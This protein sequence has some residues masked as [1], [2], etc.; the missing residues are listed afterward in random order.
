MKKF[1]FIMIFTVLLLPAVQSVATMGVFVDQ[2]IVH[3]IRINKD[4]S[5]QTQKGETYAVKSEELKTKLSN[6]VGHSARI[7]Y[8][9]SLC[10]DISLPS[11]PP[12]NIKKPSVQSK[13][14]L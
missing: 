11:A 5:F 1:I 14:P 3:I 9:N 2:K 7:L 6:Y 4:G 13:K 12:F 8:S 10:I